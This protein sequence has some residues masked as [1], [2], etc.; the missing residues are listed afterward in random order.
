[1]NTDIRLAIGFFDHPKTIKLERQLGLQGVVALMRL[2]LWAAQNRPDGVLSEMDVDDI[3][4]AARWNG[5]QRALYDVLTKLRFVDTV[6]GEPHLHDWKDHNEWQSQAG[7]RSDSNR[8]TR[9]ARACPDSYKALVD[10][11][12]K[13]ISREIYEVVTTSNDRNTT[14]QRLLTNGTTP[15]L[16]SPCLSSPSPTLPEE[17]ETS[18]RSVSLSGPGGPDVQSEI[19]PEDVPDASPEKK[20]AKKKPEPLP[21]DSEPYRLALFM[22]DTLKANVPTLKE[23]DLQKWAREFDVAL[24]NDSRMS[25]ARFVAQVI[26]WACSDIFWRTNIQSPGK[27]REKFDQLTAKMEAEAAKARTSPQQAEWKS[28]A[29]RR[30]EAN[31]QAGRDA[32]RLLFG[33]QAAQEVTHEAG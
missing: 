10:A 7:Q 17:R 16:T 33:N 32:K 2:W 28:P 14:V 4:I 1:M 11:G 5:E 31:Q 18:L 30:L 15:F 27:L 29:Q 3:E 22:Q 13:G 23:P 26:K 19:T 21:E 24:R 8:L 20:Q 25:E 12:I 6:D 9:L